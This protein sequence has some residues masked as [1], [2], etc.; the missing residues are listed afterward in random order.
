MSL[1]FHDKN[2]LCINWICIRY[3]AVANLSGSVGEPCDWGWGFRRKFRS[4]IFVYL[5][6]CFGAVLQLY[7]SFW[8]GACFRIGFPIQ[9]ASG[10]LVI[11][12]TSCLTASSMSALVLSI[13]KVLVSSEDIPLHFCE[14]TFVLI[15]VVCWIN[16]PGLQSPGCYLTILLGCSTAQLVCCCPLGLWMLSVVSG[17]RQLPSI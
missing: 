2:F 8:W 3:Y 12:S 15:T 16:Q 17:G 5:I 1:W 10:L 4:D 6:L 7:F 13:R 11:L 14:E 9:V